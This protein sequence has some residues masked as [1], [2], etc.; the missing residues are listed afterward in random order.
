MNARCV[1]A[2]LSLFV[3]IVSGP[4]GPGSAILHHYPS[5]G[6][7][8]RS[9][10]CVIYISVSF[11]APVYVHERHVGPYELHRDLFIRPDAVTELGAMLLTNLSHR[12]FAAFA[13]LASDHNE[14]DVI[15]LMAP[16]KFMS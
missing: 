4:Q 12:C 2:L 6:S 7:L 3:R 14:I 8:T 1:L 15:I 5:K 10:R 11:D 16:S 9:A 13:V